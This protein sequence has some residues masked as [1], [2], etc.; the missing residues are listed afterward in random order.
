M[1]FYFYLF[2]AV[3]SFSLMTSCVGT[4]AYLHKKT[5][6][7]SEQQNRVAAVHTSVISSAPWDEVKDQLQPKFPL[8]TELVLSE[9]L[10]RSVAEEKIILKALLAQLKVGFT[11]KLTDISKTTTKKTGEAAQEMTVINKTFA[12]PDLSKQEIGYP[13][14]FKNVAPNY[15]ENSATDL[16]TRLKYSTATALYQEI[17]LL[18]NYVKY[19][20]VRKGYDP[21]LVR[22]Q[23]TLTPFTHEEHCDAYSTISFFPDRF[24]SSPCSDLGELKGK[25]KTPFVV[26]LLVTEDFE[27]SA[28]NRSND[29][30]L[31]LG[32]GL[33]AAI[34]GIGVEGEVGAMARNFMKTS[35]NEYNSLMSVGRISDNSI[36]VKFG[37]MKT[38]S[39]DGDSIEYVMVPRTY[40]VTLLLLVPHDSDRNLAAVSRTT[41]V[42]VENGKELLWS[43]HSEMRN[44]VVLM[45]DKYRMPLPD[46]SNATK[47][48]TV[49]SDFIKMGVEIQSNRWECFTATLNKFCRDVGTTY[50]ENEGKITESCKRIKII[51]EQVW[52][53]IA[54]L[55]V[56]GQYSYTFFQVPE[57]N[58]KQLNLPDRSFVFNALDNKKT[59]TVKVTG[60]QG[61]CK[62][63]F[64]PLLKVKLNKKFVKLTP[65]SVSPSSDG[66]SCSVAFQS[67]NGK[68]G[69]NSSNSMY[70][71]ID[72]KDT[73]YRVMYNINEI[74]TPPS[75]VKF[76]MVSTMKNI[77]TEKGNGIIQLIFSGVGSGGSENIIKI[78]NASVSSSFTEQSGFM[79][80]TKKAGWLMVPKSG[81]VTIPLGNLLNGKNV[82]VSALSLVNGK[83][84]KPQ[85]L[86]F[87]PASIK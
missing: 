24:T 39:D 41:L 63:N 79:Q 44:E 28:Y 4:K 48:E 51:K 7:D 57:T 20:S 10:S 17:A 13:D 60:A 12:Q 6:Y 43:P 32:M 68:S 36:R 5:A 66:T 22:L 14:T 52:T 18:N 38:A 83:E 46:F 77:V 19:A 9:A 42:N 87:I 81:V 35:G 2:S 33:M 45:L 8:T 70:L 53:D 80:S 15:T 86:V 61:L 76:K 27:T 72:G 50:S 47:T 67:L 58:K 21:Y 65:L 3:L 1:K 49:I 82:I 85:Q 75:K 54:D 23:V 62:N 84:T 29:K 74:E 69:F 37:A 73:L 55:W 64:K 59:T 40:N 56:G 30:S 78:D 31:Q 26:P 16:N 25:G 71:E 34:N 11:Q